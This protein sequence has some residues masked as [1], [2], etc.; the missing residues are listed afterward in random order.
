MLA[1]GKHK[2]SLQT[3]EDVQQLSDEAL[4]EICLSQKAFPHL[5]SL[6]PLCVCVCVAQAS[7]SYQRLSP[8]LLEPTSLGRWRTRWGGRKGND[9][10][11]LSVSA[12]VDLISVSA[13]L[14]EFSVFLMF[15]RLALL[16]P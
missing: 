15:V 5:R 16:K 9:P 14:N 4:I 12:S 13:P 8:T 10:H 11:L 7:L 3:M 2:S 1:G 6:I